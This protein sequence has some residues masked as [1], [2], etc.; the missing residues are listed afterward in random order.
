MV[1]PRWIGDLEF[2]SNLGE[3]TL[4]RVARAP[5]ARREDQLELSDAE[6]AA[7]E[8]L[9]SSIV[10]GACFRAIAP[11]AVFVRLKSHEHVGNWK[12]T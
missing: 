10:V 3:E 11:C 8:T 7:P 6:R 4:G 2:D 5:L 12:A 1:M 9:D